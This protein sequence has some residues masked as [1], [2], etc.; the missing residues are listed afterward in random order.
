MVFTDGSTRVQ[1]SG[2]QESAHARMSKDNSSSGNRGGVAGV[3]G[4]SGW[5]GRT[6]VEC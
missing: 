1:R 6:H 3:G 4:V 5:M 2:D